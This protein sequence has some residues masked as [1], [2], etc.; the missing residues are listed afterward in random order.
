LCA[1]KAQKSPDRAKLIQF[2]DSRGP[3]TDFKVYQI[4][5]SGSKRVKEYQ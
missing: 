3:M 4:K 2:K 1:E 5:S